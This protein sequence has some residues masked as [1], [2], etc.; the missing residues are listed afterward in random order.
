MGLMRRLHLILLFILKAY[1][2]K[3]AAELAHYHYLEMPIAAILGYIFFNTTP[4]SSQ[5]A[6][7]FIIILGILIDIYL[8]KINGLYQKIRL[9]TKSFI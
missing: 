8:S 1:Q 4:I 3:S 2:V 7:A 9:R 5:I 6:G